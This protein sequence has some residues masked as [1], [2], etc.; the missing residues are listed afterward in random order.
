V[1]SEPSIR[2]RIDRE[3]NN[4]AA[5][6]D[7]PEWRLTWR[8][9]SGAVPI[10]P[11]ARLDL[12]YGPALGQKLDLFPHAD[13]DAPSV[14]FIHGGFWTRNSK[15]TFRFTV[16]GIHS[17][18]FH[19]FFI[20]YT[21]APN[22]RMDEMVGQARSATQWVHAHLEELGLACR[23]IIVVGWSSGAQLAAMTMSETHVAAGIGIS[24]V[25][26]LVPLLPATI[27]D[28]L[29]L[30][31]DEAVRNSANFNLPTRSGPFVVAYGQR[32]LPAFCAQSEQFH[33][34]RAER[35]LL[36]EILALP[37]H[38]HHSIL[39]EMWNIDGRLTRALADLSSSV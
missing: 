22:A 28:V 37:R 24:G 19:A 5:F 32:E 11:P 26:D 4:E 29:R 14:V 21:L 16:R 36:G 17:A 9:R 35:G 1:V 20:G 34:A 31:R 12:P 15:E 27:N 2:A 3:Y 6:P 25:Y 18:G 23:P 10:I 39:D 33:A 7:V 30:D 8:T 38:H 13:A